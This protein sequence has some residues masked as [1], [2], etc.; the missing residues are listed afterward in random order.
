V[1]GPVSQV[2]VTNTVLSLVTIVLKLAISWVL[3]RAGRKRQHKRQA[4]KLQKKKAA[5]AVQ[6]VEVAV[7]EWL[8]AVVVLLASSSSYILSPPLSQRACRLQ[9]PP[10]TS[11]LLVL[12]PSSSS[13]ANAL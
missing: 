13:R 11:I 10:M 1:L 12:S 4:K 6:A 2:L 8:C 7:S 5:L 9:C 3:L